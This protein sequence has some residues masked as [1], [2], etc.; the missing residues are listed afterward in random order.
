MSTFTAKAL[1]A[2]WLLGGAAAALAKPPMTPLQRGRYLIQTAGCNDCHT[3]G[4]GPNNGQVSEKLWLTG[5]ALGWS[6]PWG[7]G[8]RAPRRAH[9]RPPAVR[10]AGP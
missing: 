6:G 8:H 2:F 5:D 1:A 10:R 4:Y 9:A 3:P 7:T